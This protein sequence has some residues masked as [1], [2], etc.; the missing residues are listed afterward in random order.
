MSY[1]F[2][3]TIDTGGTEPATIVDGIN[4]TYNVWS[5]YKLAF[6]PLE[7]GVKSL[8]GKTG[9]RCIIHLRRA[10]QSMEDNRK[11]YEA[12]N[13]ENGWGNY[14]GALEVL[15]DLSKWCLD[16]PNATMRVC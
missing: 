7:G 4:Y 5:M 13:P 9:K 14:K 3:M 8:D 11:I 15:R 6:K 1:D 16:H 10:I 12:L 2:S